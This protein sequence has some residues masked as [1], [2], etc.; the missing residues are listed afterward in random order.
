MARTH[1]HPSRGAYPSRPDDK[2]GAERPSIAGP[3]SGAEAAAIKKSTRKKRRQRDRE[4]AS[5][6]QDADV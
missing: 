4:I 3:W 5:K 2:I 1:L 6:E